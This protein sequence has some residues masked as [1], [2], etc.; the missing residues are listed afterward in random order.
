MVS[1]KMADSLKSA[2]FIQNIISSR[3]NTYFL[4]ILNKK[5]ISMLKKHEIVVFYQK[6]WGV[7]W[8]KM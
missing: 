2:I 5:L 8:K 1:E 3:K 7:V 6:N 4:S